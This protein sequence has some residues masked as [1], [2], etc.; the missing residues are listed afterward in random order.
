MR[1]TVGQSGGFVG[2]TARRVDAGDLS[3]PEAERLRSLVEQSKLPDAASASTQ[4]HGNV[5]TY[6]I[7]VET[8]QGAS[9]FELDDAQAE[10]VRPLIDFVEQQGTPSSPS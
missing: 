5:P 2:Y 4:Q 8:E 9:R 10:Q 6:E 3:A 7:T 1:V